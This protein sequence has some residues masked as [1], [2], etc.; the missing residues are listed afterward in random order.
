MR[1][2][3]NKDY[4]YI[5]YTSPGFVKLN[6]RYEVSINI[7]ILQYDGEMFFV[8]KV[9]DSANEKEYFNKRFFPNMNLC[10]LGWDKRNV[11]N[12]IFTKD[13]YGRQ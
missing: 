4:Y 3:K 2:Y 10:I 5:S 7:F 9:I 12:Q 11:V 13:W 1:K 6:P 8:K